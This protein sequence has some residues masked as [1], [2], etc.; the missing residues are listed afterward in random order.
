MTGVRH[1]LPRFRA[2]LRA[3]QDGL[4][5]M[6]RGLARFADARIGANATA[7]QMR[8]AATKK[9]RRSDDKGLLRIVENRLASAVI[10]RPFAQTGAR[11]Y[12][13]ETKLEGLGR[14]AFEKTITVPYAATHEYGDE[15]RNIP[16]RAFIAPA[17]KEE[18]PAI[19][20]EGE[21]RLWDLM[22]QT[23]GS[24]TGGGKA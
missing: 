11:E 14:L 23:I 15:G 13:I 17:I 18:G 21:K 6:L 8:R 10:S 7:R 4:P 5:E 24:P 19:E 22:N 1:D 2:D 16:Q 20:A 3:F 12:A 9:R